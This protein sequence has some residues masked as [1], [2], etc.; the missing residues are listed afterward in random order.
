[1]PE[2]ASGAAPARYFVRDDAGTVTGPFPA[3]E[4]RRMASAGTLLPSWLLS[5]D[6]ARWSPAAKVP[7]L[8]GAVD[9]ALAARPPEGKKHRELTPSEQVGLLIDRFVLRDNDFL[10]SFPLLTPLRRFVARLLLPGSVV[11]ARATSSGTSYVRFDPEKGTETPIDRP[12]ADRLRADKARATPVSGY[13][14]LLVLVPW[15]WWLIQD[16]SLTWA[17]LKALALGAFALAAKI[18]DIRNT[19]VLVGYEMDD[20]TRS[21][22]LAVRRAFASL[23]ASSKVWLAR[24]EAHASAHERKQS[25]GAEMR[26][27]RMPA[28]LFSRA[29]P[30]M[31][32]NVRALGLAYEDKAVYFL[33]DCVMVMHASGV[34]YL[35]YADLGIEAAPLEV[36]DT[37]RAR[38]ADAPLVRMAYRFPNRD[39]SPDRRYAENPQ[40]VPVYRFGRLT[41]SVGGDTVELLTANP[42][43]AEGFVGHFRSRPE[44]PPVHRP[45]GGRPG[46]ED[47]PEEVDGAAGLSPEEGDDGEG[48]QTFKEWVEDVVLPALAVARA[49]PRPLWVAAVGV[50]ALVLV[51]GWAREAW[52]AD[53]RALD[54][55]DALHDA[56]KKGEAA[57]IYRKLP[58]R[59]L[60]PDGSGSR[61][62]RRLVAQDARAGDAAEAKAWAAKALDAGLAL[63]FNAGEEEAADILS[64]LKA[65]RRA[66]E[67]AAK[68]EAERARKAAEAEADRRRE[69]EG[70]RLAEEKKARDDAERARLAEAARLRAEREKEAAAGFLRRVRGWLD[71]LKAVTPAE[72]REALRALADAGVK[73]AEA[74]PGAL[75]AVSALLRD[76]SEGVRRSAFQAAC[77]VGGSNESAVPGLVDALKDGDAAVRLHAAGMLKLLG[78][79]A[80][81]AAPALVGALA[82]AKVKS[83]ASEA[84]G[85][86]GAGA[87]PALLK[88]LD[89]ADDDAR[90][91]AAMTLGHIGPAAKDAL[92]RLAKLATDDDGR[93]VREAAET[94]VRRIKGAK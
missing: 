32:T 46:R 24:L 47:A 3:T 94:A 15:A 70:R 38:H 22:L 51:G 19:R 4:L 81:G 7:G 91:M 12:Q 8:F 67:A 60:R 21:R 75:A 53:E 16:F 10:A 73:A 35:D 56:G 18:R 82:D 43:A 28:V 86:I 30:G 92:P 25:A 83:A 36:P 45:A 77:A 44:A 66:A 20:A 72:R 84:L 31:D 14:M 65:D 11:L 5:Q 34:S 68:A 2:P 23:S 85:A 52:Y 42:A 57:A 33:P 13:L 62:L 37:E 40:D 64:R 78:A 50:T 90:R 63:E 48:R 74:E 87:V 1:M 71:G 17:A 79:E 6:R 89:G 54:R 58:G 76:P 93:R 61:W 27:S 29:V 55:A 26:L 9:A 88:A 59:L 39:G 69:A 49:V 41:L 80:A